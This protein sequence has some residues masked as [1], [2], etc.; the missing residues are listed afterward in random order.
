MELL[1]WEPDAGVVGASVYN[2][3]GNYAGA[4]F[5]PTDGSAGGDMGEFLD[6][7]FSIGQVWLTAWFA[8]CRVGGAGGES[9]GVLMDVDGS[10]FGNLATTTWVFVCAI[11]IASE[12]KKYFLSDFS[13][14]SDYVGCGSN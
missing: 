9:P 1:V 11:S 8:G 12:L 10:V 6:F 2:N 7:C 4:V 3:A 14:L 5:A 13:Y